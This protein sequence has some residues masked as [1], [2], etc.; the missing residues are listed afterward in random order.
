MDWD[1]KR[2]DLD[3]FLYLYWLSLLGLLL[4]IWT[5]CIVCIFS[6]LFFHLSSLLLLSCSCCFDTPIFLSRIN[7]ALILYHLILSSNVILCVNICIYNITYDVI[8]FIQARWLHGPGS[9]PQ[10]GRPGE[11]TPQEQRGWWREGCGG[12]G[13]RHHTLCLIRMSDSNNFFSV[14]RKWMLRNWRWKLIKMHP[15]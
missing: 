4:C 11:E 3:I 10:H 13:E 14:V 1:G 8:A 5:Y 7:K 6:Y 2:C 9:H 15:C 12:G